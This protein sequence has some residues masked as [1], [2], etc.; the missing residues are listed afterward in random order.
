MFAAGI[1]FHAGCAIVMGLNRFVWAFAPDTQLCCAPIWRSARNRRSYGER[2]HDRRGSGGDR[3]LSQRVSAHVFRSPSDRRLCGAEA[4]I[5]IRAM[6]T[7]RE[8][9]AGGPGPAPPLAAE[10]TADAAARRRWGADRSPRSPDPIRARRSPAPAVRQPPPAS[11]SATART[12]A[13][14]EHLSQLA[15]ARAGAPFWLLSPVSPVRPG[16]G[17]EQGGLSAA[18]AEEQIHILTPVHA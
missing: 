18:P 4:I 12:R 14:S 16:R 8:A 10:L 1:A 17:T 15:P 2:D 11:P 13:G 6:I 7:Q 5:K 9:R 3:W